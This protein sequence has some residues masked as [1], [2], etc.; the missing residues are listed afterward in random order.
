MPLRLTTDEEDACWDRG[1]IGKGPTAL[2]HFDLH[3][4]DEFSEGI[5]KEAITVFKELQIPI[6]DI[7]WYGVLWQVT[8][9][10][11]TDLRKVP[12]CI[13]HQPCYYRFESE[14]AKTDSSALRVKILEGVDFDDTFYAKE[15]NALLR[16]GIMVS[17][18]SRSVVEDGRTVDRYKST[19]SGILVVDRDGNLFITVAAHGF[20]EDGIVWHPTPNRGRVIGSIV[21][22]LSGT[23]IAIV[24]LNSG[25]RYINGMFG[26]RENPNGTRTNGLSPN[27][28]PHTR[29][30]DNLRMDTPFSGFCEGLVLGLG[31]KVRG[32]DTDYI[33]QM[34]SVF[35][36]G[37]EP[38]DGCCGS[39]ILDEQGRVVAFFR[40]KMNQSGDCFGV[41]AIELRR[42]GYE[43]CGEEQTF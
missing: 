2:R 16:P 23:D 6:Q 9:P 7:V 25:I 12:S 37:D 5:I 43:I 36:N 41:S 18:S 27:C 19:T 28:P 31:M 22:T 24:K 10:D 26:T 42:H 1:K 34:W 33:G 21:K 15:P 13:A 20:E 35:E 17:S 8:V 3:R 29:V 38:I 30:G 32:D 4:R 40:Y 14:V 39:A 11:G